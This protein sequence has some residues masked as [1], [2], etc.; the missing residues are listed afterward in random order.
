[1]SRVKRLLRGKLICGIFISW[2]LC[3]SALAKDSSLATIELSNSQFVRASETYFRDGA[4]SSQTSWKLG[5]KARTDKRGYF[6]AIDVRNDF[7]AEEDTHYLKPFDLVLG[8]ERQGMRTSLGR[9]RHE[10]SVADEHWRIGMWQP[11]F[12][13]DQVARE[14]AG[15]TGLFLRV[16]D[17]KLKLM[18]FASPYWFPDMKADFKTKNN[19]FMS[20]NPWFRPPTDIVNLDGVPTEVRY[21]F[22]RPATASVVEHAMAAAQVEFRPTDS[23]FV[24]V[25][26]AY[27]P[28]NQLMIGFPLELHLQDPNYATVDVKTR[29]LYQQLTT[30]E[31][32]LRDSEGITAWA[33]VSFER[34]IRDEP[35]LEWTT[36]ELKDS[37]V[38]SVYFGQNLRGSGS[39]ATHAFISYLRV[40][41]GDAADRGDFTSDE[42]FFESRYMFKNAVQVG[43]RHPT[44]LFTTRFLAYLSGSA[45][46]DFAQHGVMVSGRVQQAFTKSWSGHVAMDFLGLIDR[47]GSQSDGFISTYRANDRISAG[48]QYVF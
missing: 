20:K 2:C 46:Y 7:R 44:P 15:F 43:I 21:S 17:P 6:A 39:G 27:K 37:V 40:E 36:Q 47:S 35:P 19:K 25:S 29:V 4:S 48:V 28:V 42:S 24:R 1:M 12:A 23:R 5:W 32:G 8:A 26:T 41:G 45:L 18:F 14:S 11:R 3:Y 38:S 13:D 31:G 22:N 16:G 34:P 30:I 10:W 9:E 33:S